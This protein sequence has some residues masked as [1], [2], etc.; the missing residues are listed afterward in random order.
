MVEVRRRRAGLTDASGD[1]P[2]VGSVG[3]ARGDF[4]FGGAS[5]CLL[6]PGNHKRPGQDCLTRSCGNQP[7]FW[8]AGWL[9][10]QRH[11]CG[12]ALGMVTRRVSEGRTAKRSL[13]DASG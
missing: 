11:F 2:I 4:L 3:R 12:N 1:Q 7:F 13:A 8:D 10:G 6:L 5:T 9:V